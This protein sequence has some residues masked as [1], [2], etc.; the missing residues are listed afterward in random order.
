MTDITTRPNLDEIEE[1]VE[2]ATVGPWGFEPAGKSRCGEPQCCSEYWD[3]R[4]WGGGMVLTESHMLP[5]A[6]AEFIAAA[7]TDVP[8]LTAALQDV[9]ALHVPHPEPQRMVTGVIVACSECGDIDDSPTE[10]PCPTVRAIT[11]HIDIE[12]N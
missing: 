10:Y 12:R 9:L 2:G 1:R 8:A 3:N 4:I 7:R 6:D 5:A 11:A